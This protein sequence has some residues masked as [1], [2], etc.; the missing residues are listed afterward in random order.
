M[1]LAAAIDDILE[2]RKK[3]AVKRRAEQIYE[4][5]VDLGIMAIQ[6]FYEAYTP[7]VYERMHSF[8]YVC[9]PFMHPE[10]DGYVVGIR[11][12]EGVAAGHKDPD[13][14]VFH[15]V[16]WMGVHGTSEIA[17]STPPMTF[18]KSYFSQFKGR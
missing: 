16:M 17:V 10:K 8:D 11:V 13:E 4:D 15:G 3:D 9:S 1:S 2:K 12:L 18:I 5:C 14:Y 7:K 6:Q